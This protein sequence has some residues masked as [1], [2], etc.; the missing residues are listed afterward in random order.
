MEIL[1][2]HHYQFSGLLTS[3]ASL[4]LVIL[5]YKKGVDQYLKKRFALY[6]LSLF[7]W[8]LSLFICTSVYDYQAAYFFTQMTHVGAIMIP[9]L[10]LHFTFAYLNSMSRI[11]RSLLWILYIIAAFF[12]VIN[13][14]FR[15]LFF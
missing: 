6:Y 11:Q 13:L 2:A 15:D 3:A 5:V 14:F 10:F 12:M 7:V 9:V 8:S 4:F 1:P